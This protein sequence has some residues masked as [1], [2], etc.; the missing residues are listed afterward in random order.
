MELNDNEF[1]LLGLNILGRVL[2][3]EK[4]ARDRFRS[5][6][7]T[8]PVVAADLWMRLQSSIWRERKSCK[9]H[10][11]LWCL[12]F[13]KSYDK[14]MNMAA[15]VGCDEKTWRKWIWCILR[16]IN[17]LK[18]E[19]VSGA[20][21]RL[22]VELPLVLAQCYGFITDQTFKQVSWR[23]TTKSCHGC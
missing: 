13:L 5:N 21:I 9:P 22:G 19:V 15:K 14:E 6:F 3:S 7:G 12:M 16:E 4:V 11:L 17:V 10:H 20:W 2:K 1:L 8:E 18:H 23:H